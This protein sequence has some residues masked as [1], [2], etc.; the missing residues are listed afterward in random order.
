MVPNVV[1]TFFTCENTDVAMLLLSALEILVELFSC[2]GN[3]VVSQWN[4][5]RGGYSACAMCVR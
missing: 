3:G 1:C 5:V 2:M 4:S